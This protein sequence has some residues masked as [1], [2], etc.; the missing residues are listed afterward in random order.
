MI[1]HSARTGPVI[2]PGPGVRYGTAA[3]HDTR[4]IEN[5]ID[6][7]LP[8]HTSRSPSQ[9]LTR[10]YLGIFFPEFRV[11]TRAEEGEAEGSRRRVK[12][13]E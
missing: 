1:W 10:R 2:Q 7:P 12:V 4:A 11:P 8:Q 13:G 6:M 9:D 3:C 5:L